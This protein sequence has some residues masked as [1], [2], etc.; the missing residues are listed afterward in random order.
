MTTHQTIARGAATISLLV[1]LLTGTSYGQNHDRGNRYA[2]GRGCGPYCNLSFKLHNAFRIVA[3]D[4][5]ANECPGGGHSA[6]F[7]NWGVDSGWGEPENGH[8]FDGWKSVFLGFSQRQWNSCTSRQDLYPFGNPDFYNYPP[9]GYWEQITSTGLNSYTY[10]SGRSV[11]VTCP[12]FE[13]GGCADL[14]GS[15]FDLY[16]EWLDL[17]E[18]DTGEPPK[19]D[20]DAYVGRLYVWPLS[21]WPLDC[22]WD[23]CTYPWILSDPTPAWGASFDIYADIYMEFLGGSFYDPTGYCGCDEFSCTPILP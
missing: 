19:F 8:Q 13:A 10:T 5:L 22:E 6:P 3:A 17:F 7:G 12:F 14:D 18:L 21:V 20:P 1:L 4:W 2:L 23:F 15:S 9:G 11:G 16:G